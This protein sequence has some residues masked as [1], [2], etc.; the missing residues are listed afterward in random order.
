MN[1]NHTNH[2]DTIKQPGE[3]FCVADGEFTQSVEFNYEAVDRGNPLEAELTGAASHERN[4]E[5]AEVLH[6]LLHWLWMKPNGKTRSVKFAVGRLAALT[7]LISPDVFNGA[8]YEQVGRL[9][10]CG[11]A[12][13][14]RLAV[15]LQRDFGFR[16]RRVQAKKKK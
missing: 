5:I 1:K 6:R 15:E 2:K 4:L 13:V 10:K 7:V 3:H 9:T 16:C 14:S 12:N 11:K 8:T